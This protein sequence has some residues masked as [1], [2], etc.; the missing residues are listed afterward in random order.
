MPIRRAVVQAFFAMA[1]AGAAC[2][3]YAAACTGHGVELQVLGSGG[4]EMQAKR[5]SSS[6][7]IWRDGKARV[8]VDAGGGAALRFGEAGANMADLDVVLFTHFHADHSA[9]FAALVKS[10]YFEDR[11]RALPVLGPVGNKRFPSATEF[12]Q[13]LFDEKRGAYRY[14]SDYLKGGDSVYKLE[15]K[16]IQLK[17]TEVMQVYSAGGIIATATPVIHGAVPALAW[18]VDVDGARIAFSGDTNG[19]NG[20]LEHLVEGTDIFVAHNAVPEG[21]MGIE[22]FLHMPP[23]VIGNIAEAGKVKSLVLSHRMLRTLGKEQQTLAVI[24]ERYK[25][26]VKFAEDLDCFGLGVR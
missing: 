23:S 3:V 15:T 2:A 20:N 1:C 21:T 7:L 8:L 10:S 17:S 5:A 26:P 24:G 9:D 6:Y 19:N 16:T 14:L 22:R 18:R 4:P 25:G 12:V 11:T 13:T